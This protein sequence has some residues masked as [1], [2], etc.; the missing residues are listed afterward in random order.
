MNWTPRLCAAAAVLCVVLWPDTGSAQPTTETGLSPRQLFIR[1]TSGAGS[2]GGVSNVGEVIADLVGL[3]VSTAPIGSSAGGFTFIFDPTTRAFSRAAP[4]F[5]P[6]LG[7]R[8]IT[9]GEGRASFGIN[10]IH[11][12]YDT[13][14]SVDI[15]DG[16]LT[17]VTLRAGA[18]PLFAG[19][20]QLDI[21]TDTVVFFTNVALN[22]WFDASVAV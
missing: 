19:T 9:A 17:T 16:S 6:M 13:M 12:T 14:D 8:A 22:R 11:T 5:G 3:E 15:R 20:A 21:T 4:S 10:Y 18:S 2:A 1:M 7:E